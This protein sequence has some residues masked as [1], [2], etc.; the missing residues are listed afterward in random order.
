MYIFCF[1]HK[2][3]FIPNAGLTE[4]GIDP[5][6]I[7]KIK[8][9]GYD[10]FPSVIDKV[11]KIAREAEDLMRVQGLQEEEN[12]WW[13]HI[14]YSTLPQEFV[15]GKPACKDMGDHIVNE[16]QWDLSV[17]EDKTK[18]HKILEREVAPTHQHE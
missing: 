5:P 17:E 13:K 15:G 6:P 4:L 7:F 11:E 8:M 1:L 10:Q 18:P 16:A 9:V 2:I 3:A 14:V 12:N